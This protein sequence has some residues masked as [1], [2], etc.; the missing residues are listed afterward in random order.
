MVIRYLND[1]RI[2]FFQDM[3]SGGASGILSRT[4]TAPLDVVKIRSEIGTVESKFGFRKCFTKLYRAEGIR[5][6]WKGNL[7]GCMKILPY[8]VLQFSTF[9]KVKLL[10]ADQQGRLSVPNAVFAGATAGSVAT[11]LTYPVELVKTRLIAQNVDKRIA[12]YKG[13]S[14]AFLTIL[15]YDGFR[16]YYHGLSVT[17]AGW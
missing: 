5:A 2:T 12:H 8:S 11:I 1:H 9:H 10:L 4:L 7:I 17:L 14:H 3:I 16:G 6:F 13:I 15:K